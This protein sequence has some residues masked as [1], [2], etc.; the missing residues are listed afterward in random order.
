MTRRRLL[1]LTALFCFALSSVALA[2][3][4][5]P[6][7]LHVYGGW[8]PLTGNA[9]DVLDSGWVLDFGG[10]WTPDP[11]RPLGLRFDLGYNWWDVQTGALPSGDL[12]VDGGDANDWS[13]RAAAF[14]QMRNKGRAHFNA[15]VGIGGYS[16]HGR[17]TNTVLVPGYICDPWWGWCY[18][19]VVQGQQIVASKTTTKIGYNATVGVSIETSGS[20]QVFVE[21][22]YHYVTLSNTLEYWPIVV[23]YRW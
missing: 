16:V 22:Q 20:G 2:Q 13:L 5:K 8:S 23:G 3:S 19:G 4:D 17:L 9:S 6:V 12:K 15:S 14:F 18:P 21:A 10:V 7:Q 11:Q 1:P